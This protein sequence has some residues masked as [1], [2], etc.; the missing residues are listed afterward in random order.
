MAAEKEKPR[1]TGNVPEKV[2]ADRIQGDRGENALVV[3]GL[4][5]S[6]GAVEAVRGVD[7]LVRHGEIFGLSGPDGAGKSSVFQILAGVMPAT[8]G[9]TNI[10]GRPAREA[11]SY[12]GYLTQ[13]FSL[14]HDLSVAE[15]MRYMGELR[16]LSLEEIQR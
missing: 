13:V 5:K 8:S 15:N 4:R 11:R 16:R 12:V 10:L 2:S 14:Y 6:Y 1:I 9:E 3:Y 7:L